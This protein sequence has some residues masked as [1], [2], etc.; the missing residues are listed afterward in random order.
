MGTILLKDLRQQTREGTVV[1]FGLVLPL[2]LAFVLGLA[3]GDQPAGPGFDLTT[4]LA[5]GS[6]VFFLFFVV[7]GM[8]GL[9]RERH[10]G[11]LPRLLAAPVGDAAILGAKLV[12][13]VLL[14]LLSMTALVLIT[15]FLYGARWGPPL[16]VA[17]LVSATVLAASGL[18][19][20]VA[21]FARTAEQAVNQ[22]GALAVVLG[23]TGGALFPLPRT[24]WVEWVSLLAPH[25]WFLRGLEEGEPA[26]PVAVLLGMALVTGA[27]AV[28]RAGRTLRP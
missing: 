22:Q 13:G 10:L 16:Q 12:A 23:L 24:G 18:S 26:L 20:A 8:T 7:S 5:A 11:T 3:L 27:V 6:S 1:L 28:A 17:A 9:L 15:T 2:V 19:A 21:A 14:G 25:H 4:R